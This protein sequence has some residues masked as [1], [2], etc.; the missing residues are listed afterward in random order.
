[1]S[2]REITDWQGRSFGERVARYVWRSKPTR[3]PVTDRPVRCIVAQDEKGQ[4]WAAT[5]TGQGDGQKPQYELWE[6]C[7]TK[8]EAMAISR[9]QARVMLGTEAELYSNTV[10]DKGPGEQ[11]VKIT[12]DDGWSVTINAPGKPAPP[13]PA[14]KRVMKLFDELGSDTK[15]PQKSPSRGRSIDR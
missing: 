4:Y 6:P 5:R 15:P 3:S 8:Q 10:T 1:M 12:M 9:Q 14:F 13:S 7:A 11:I 2:K